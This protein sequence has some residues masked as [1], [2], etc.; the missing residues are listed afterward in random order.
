MK[1]NARFLAATLALAASACSKSEPS[2]PAAPV[3]PTLASISPSSGVRGATILVT[4]TGS[5]FAVGSTQIA[6]GGGYVFATGVV[7]ETAT[8]ITENFF[9]SPSAPLGDIPVEAT[10]GSLVSGPLQFTVLPAPPTLSSVAP[11]FGAQ[12]TTVAVTLTGTNFIAGATT[13]TVNGLGVATNSVVVTS[14]TS[15]TANIVIAA[16]AALGADGVSV[17]TAGGTTASKLF[18]V[19]AAAPVTNVIKKVG[20]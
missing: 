5:N 9:I 12:G 6:T 1:Y 17:T 15:L 13:I 7:T 11:N 20:A 16:D 14:T 3:G 10:T 18:T 19:N 4:L 2:A 8:S